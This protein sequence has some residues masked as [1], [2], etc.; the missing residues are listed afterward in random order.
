[1]N[2]AIRWL[3]L[4][5]TVLAGCSVG[6]DPPE[7]GGTW[8]IDAVDQ[9]G[10][11]GTITIERGEILDLPGYS[12]PAF[13]GATR[14]IAVHIT[15]APQRASDTGYGALDWETSTAA[16]VPV[17]GRMGL[18]NPVPAEADLPE[19]SAL[20]SVLPDVRQVLSGWIVIPVSDEV[21][22]GPVNL[23]Y[24]P[25]LVPAGGNGLTSQLVSEI[26]IHAP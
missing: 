16:E 25:F 24:Q 6:L 13:P 17:E 20:G 14:G 5:M 11:F 4:A 1:M 23:R 8:Q 2:R 18:T 3:S 10:V 7:V 19:G 12:D 22:K 9:A 21:L 15:Y 26:T